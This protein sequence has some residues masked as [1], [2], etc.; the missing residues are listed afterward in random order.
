MKCLRNSKH[1]RYSTVCLDCLETLNKHPVE[2]NLDDLEPEL[3]ALFV[4]LKAA[5]RGVDGCWFPPQSRFKLRDRILRAE[6]LYY[7]FYKADIN[8][9]LLKT[10]CANKNC[11][12]PA[13]KKSR[14]EK[15]TL[16]KTVTSGFNRKRTDFTEIPDAQWLREA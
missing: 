8:N 5:T 16:N 4:S 12:N 14:R 6:N 7:A 1:T 13:H 15:P 11:V 3:R 9:E 2:P 10:T